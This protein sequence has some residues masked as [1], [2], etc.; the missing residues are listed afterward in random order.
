MTVSSQG[1]AGHAGAADLKAIPGFYPTPSSVVDLMLDRLG[2]VESWHRALEPSAGRGDIADRLRQHAGEVIVVEPN[3]LLVGLLRVKGYSP[4]E[5]TFEEFKVVGGFDK[6]AMNPPFAA[7]LDMVH[8]RRAFGLLNGGGDLVALMNDG[9]DARDG[10]REQRAAFSDWLMS[11]PGIARMS[12][13][14]LRPELFLSTENLRPSHVP[15][16]IVCITK[17]EGLHGL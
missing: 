6:I 9:D 7:G 10:T 17:T 1:C 16:K 2:P 5:C 11:E 8:V 4:A 15:M 14:R 3:A 12:M 13:D